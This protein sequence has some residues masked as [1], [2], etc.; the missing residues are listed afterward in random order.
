MMRPNTC[1]EKVFYQHC[2][3]LYVATGSLGVIQ[4]AL[5]LLDPLGV[6]IA[7]ATVTS[8]RRLLRGEKTYAGHRSHAYQLAS[9]LYGRHLPVTSAVVA[10]N[11]FW[12]LPLAACV[13]L[14]NVDGML[15]LIIAY[16]PFVQL[17]VR[18]NLASSRRHNLKAKDRVLFIGCPTV[19][20]G[21]AFI[22][23]G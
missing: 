4:A 8:S 11:M 13:A 14:W 16:V 21:A 9:R 22:R 6:F 12:L 20:D 7:E 23:N 17:A 3:G 2:P 10:I 15:A 5:G 19:D 1:V 18:F